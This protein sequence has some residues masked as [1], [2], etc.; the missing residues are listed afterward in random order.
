MHKNT[1][2]LFNV[3]MYFSTLSVNLYS[4]QG[5]GTLDVS[6]PIKISITRKNRTKTFN[7]NLRIRQGTY[8]KRPIFCSL[9]FRKLY[10]IQLYECTNQYERSICNDRSLDTVLQNAYYCDE[11]STSASNY[12]IP[13]IS[14]STVNFLNL[15]EEEYFQYSLLYDLPSYEEMQKY[16]QCVD[17]M[18]N[19]YEHYK[20]KYSPPHLTEFSR[21]MFLDCKRRFLHFVDDSIDISFD[22]PLHA[23]LYQDLIYKSNFQLSELVDII[24]E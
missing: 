7:F 11:W 16:R 1:K 21:L 13:D 8:K 14:D 9:Q 22:I 6:I 17:V 3:I 18:L 10:A 2:K 15:C 5:K 19:F 24:E 23:S 4:S 12:T 20:K